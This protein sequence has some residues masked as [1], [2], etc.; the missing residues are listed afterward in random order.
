MSSIFPP[1][2]EINVNYSW[3]D[4]QNATGYIIFDGLGGTDNVSTKYFIIPTTIVASLASDNSVKS[5]GN[6]SQTVGIAWSKGIDL[7]FDTSDY[8][9][10]Q[11]L[12][13]LGYFRV[14]WI[15]NALSAGFTASSY[16]IIKVRK[17]N[18]TTET[19]IASAQTATK[20]ITGITTGNHGALL[21]IE[22]PETTIKVGEQLRI[23]AEVWQSAQAMGVVS[24]ALKFDPEDTSNNSRFQMAVPFKIEV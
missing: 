1:G 23:T 21:Q 15:T 3:T 4:I 22:I 5:S 17:W 13:G 11:T 2:K 19:E 7:D 10:P 6:S 18:G 14:E 9:L 8:N 16:V 24:V 20:T 12:K